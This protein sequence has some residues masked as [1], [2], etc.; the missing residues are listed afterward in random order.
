MSRSN[1]KRK[2]TGVA[3]YT[4]T[5]QQDKIIRTII[6]AVPVA[7]IILGIVVWQIRRRK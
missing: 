1:S 4:A 2:N 7:I 3:T 5:V 6:I